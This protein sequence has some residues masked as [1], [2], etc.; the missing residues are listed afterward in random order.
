MSNIDKLA[1]ETAHKLQPRQRHLGCDEIKRNDR[2]ELEK[3]RRNRFNGLIDELAECIAD[4]CTTK[5]STEKSSILRLTIE[6]FREQEIVAAEKAAKEPSGNTKPVFV[7]DDEFSFVF[8]ESSLAFVFAVDKIGN[9]IYTSDNVLNGVGH[10]PSHILQRN[11]FDFIHVQDHFIFQGLLSALRSDNQFHHSSGG[12]GCNLAQ[13]FEPFSCHFRRGPYSQGNGLEI[14]HCFGTILWSLPKEKVPNLDVSDCLVV[15]AK[16]LNRA[17]LNTTILRSDG[18]QTKFTATLKI[19]AKYDYLDKRVA[20]VLGF[21]PSELIGN[22]LYEYCHHEDLQDLM[23]YHKILLLTGS[24]TTCYYRHLTKGHSWIWLRSQYHLSY[25]DWSAKPQAVTCLSWVVPYEEVCTKQREILACDREKSAQIRVGYGSTDGKSTSSNNST[26]PVVASP[27]SASKITAD[28]YS[29]C[30]SVASLERT[31][32]SKDSQTDISASQVPYND[33]L[34]A[35]EVTEFEGFLRKLQVPED[36][37]TAQHDLHV[38]LSRMYM[39]LISAI[40]KQREELGNIQKQIRIQGDLVE[41]L[42]KIKAKNNIEEEY[43]TTREIREKIEEI[44]RI[45]GGSSAEKPEAESSGVCSKRR[46]EIGVETTSHEQQALVVLGREPMASREV[47]QQHDLS[48]MQ[49]EQTSLSQRQQGVFFNQ[50][51]WLQTQAQQA[52]LHQQFLM[53]QLRNTQYFMPQERIPQEQVMPLLY[54][55]QQQQQQLEQISRDFQQQQQQH[56]NQAN[57]ALLSQEQM[58]QNFIPQSF[59]SSNTAAIG[60]GSLQGRST[61]TNESFSNTFGQHMRIPLP[62][63]PPME[64]EMP[65]YNSLPHW[66]TSGDP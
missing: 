66:P 10:L 4:R 32:G 16:P 37:T 56:H 39:Q 19:D 42:E 62:P 28:N 60:S 31:V 12:S 13:R 9:L 47:Q 1:Q 46:P 21:F 58:S 5:R 14:I 25:S 17:P 34:M 6:Y 27:A 22:S 54:Q 55:H 45:C 38:F 2:N 20:S 61:L 49:V 30:P 26:I 24:M 65:V 3:K 48:I 29:R 63:S 7:T 11:I 52:Q 57:Q 64:Y 41:R 59:I 15:L 33:D 8:L 36:L 50:E 18:P 43:S 53:Q 51:Q 44:H 23:E 35:N 40:N